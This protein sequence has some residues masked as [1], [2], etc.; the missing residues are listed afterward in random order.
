MK[1]AVLA[2]GSKGNS[3]YIE[4]NNTK[5]L[6]D[7]GMSNLYIENK[8]KDLNIEPNDI[9]NI[10][11]THTHVDHIAGLRVFIKKHKPHVFLNNKM[12]DDYLNAKVSQK[13]TD[14]F[15]VQRK[16]G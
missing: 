1:I 15:T 5:S 4:K 13:K 10:F 7:V 2:S 16:G 8:L 11:I 6:I 9:D 12:Y 14:E 3:T